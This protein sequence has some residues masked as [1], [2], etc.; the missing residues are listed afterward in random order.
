MFPRSQLGQMVNVS[1][2]RAV[3]ITG[4]VA[5]Q[6]GRRVSGLAVCVTVSCWGKIM[7]SRHGQRVGSQTFTC[8]SQLLTAF[9]R[10]GTLV[11]IRS[12]HYYYRKG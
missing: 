2:R 12:F 6:C 9:R 11:Y 5:Q 10:M 7:R 8:N 4:P 3:V 1:L